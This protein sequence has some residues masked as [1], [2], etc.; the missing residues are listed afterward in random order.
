MV[1]AGQKDPK[2]KIHVSCCEADIGFAKKLGAG[3][4]ELGRFD[5]SVILKPQRAGKVTRPRGSALIARADTVLF[6]LSPE[7][8]SSASF[9]QDA[10]NADDLS[11]RMLSLVARPLRMADVPD[12]LAGLKPQRFDDARHFDSRLQAL[13]RLLDVDACWVRTHTRIFARACKWQQDGFARKWLLSGPEI[14]AAK[15]WTFERSETAPK[16]TDLHMQFILASEAAG[17][18][19]MNG[20]SRVETEPAVV[21]ASPQPIERKRSRRKP[22]KARKEYTSFLQQPSPV[23]SV[24]S[25]FHKAD[26]LQAPKAEPVE[27]A[28]PADDVATKRAEPAVVAAAP[29]T[30]ARE[31]QPEAPEPEA[32]TGGDVETSSAEPAPVSVEPPPLT[33]IASPQPY[34]GAPEIAEADDDSQDVAEPADPPAQD[35]PEPETSPLKQ[36]PKAGKAKPG[37]EVVINQAV[38]DSLLSSLLAEADNEASKNQ[39]RSR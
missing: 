12:A 28:A 15:R 1:A 2:M 36:K 31:P 35:Q 27:E 10:Q 39:P 32:A 5:V 17:T 24:L 3:L 23:A 20:V 19:R 18:A 7:A 29:E 34:A 6:V 30:P 11:K 21:P 33:E 16:P 26:K 4:K 14:I 22:K 25:M 9:I 37:S 13:V 8:V 38:L